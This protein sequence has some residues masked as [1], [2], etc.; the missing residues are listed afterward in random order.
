MR[1]RGTLFLLI[2]AAALGRSSM[3]RPSATAVGPGRT[4]VYRINL[5]VHRGRS[6]LP[7]AELRKSLEE[8]NSIWLSQAGV[9]FEITSVRDDST[10]A[11]GFDIWF[12]PEVPDPP[13]VNGVFKGD[14]DVWSRDYPNLRPAIKPVAYRAARTSAHELGHG[15][16][17]RHYDGFADS[18]DSLMGSGFLGWQLHDF[19]IEAARARARQ[20]ANPNLIPTSCSPPEI[21]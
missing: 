20:K 9:C 3:G 4:P 19:E 8:M 1:I 18:A 2:V 21:D 11:N 15:L 5:R 6:A 17:L 16:S 7:A 12:V 13:G 14:H 10:A